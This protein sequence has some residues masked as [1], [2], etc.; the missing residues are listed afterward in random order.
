MAQA[1]S[2][3]TAIAV[4]DGSYKDGRGTAAFILAISNNFDERGHI[5][6]VNSIPGEK[7]DQTSYCSKISGVS[8]IVKTVGIICKWHSITSGVVKVGLDGDQAM[9]NIFGKWPLHP[10]QADY[11]ILKDLR[12]EIKKSPLTWTGLWVE[13]HHQDHQ[14]QF[15]DLDRW[16]QLNMECNRLAKHY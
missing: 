2:N 10:K 8:G 12:K 3:C 15:K 7:E 9:K 14:L 5:V 11:D 4:S 16:S 13:G 6:G 1:I